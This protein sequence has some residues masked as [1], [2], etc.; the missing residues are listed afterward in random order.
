MHYYWKVYKTYIIIILSI[1]LIICG[2][3]YKNTIYDT[4]VVLSEEADDILEKKEEPAEEETVTELITVYVCGSVKAPSNITLSKDARIEDAVRLAGGPT[5]KADLNAINMA[6]KLS[7]EDMIYVP[8]KGEI[9]ESTEKNIIGAA[10]LKTKGRL[11]INKATAVE[12]DEL[13]GIGPSI[14]NKIIE[15]RKSSGGFKS[16]EELNNV[17]GIGDKKYDDLKDLVTIN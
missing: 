13:P 17:S 2:I 9:T 6:Q 15:Y 16:I 1:S 5:E 12:L 14:A 7:D 8:E 11:N 3:I 4:Q 10:S